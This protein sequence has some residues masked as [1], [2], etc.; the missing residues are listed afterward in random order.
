MLYI[1]DTTS[2]LV[3]K[4]NHA[5]AQRRKEFIAVFYRCVFAPLREIKLILK[6]EKPVH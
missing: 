6:S 2:I 1:F 5:K 3:K 4:I